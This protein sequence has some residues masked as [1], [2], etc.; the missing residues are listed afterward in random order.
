MD[1]YTMLKK[2]SPKDYLLERWLYEI[3]QWERAAREQFAAAVWHAGRL[4]FTFL[5]N[6]VYCIEGMLGRNY[7]IGLYQVIS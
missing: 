6:I 7:R 1:S 5:N 4:Q 3:E 2:I